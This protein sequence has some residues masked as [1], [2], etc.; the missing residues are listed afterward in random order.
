MGA[1]ASSEAEW[2]KQRGVEEPELWLELAGC[3][4]KRAQVRAT[5]ATLGVG[6]YVAG[7]EVACDPSQ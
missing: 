7:W 3:T 1:S 5:D 6:R 2:L 4:P